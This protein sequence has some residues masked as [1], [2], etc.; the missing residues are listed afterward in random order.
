SPDRL[1]SIRSAFQPLREVLEMA[2]QPLLVVPPCLAVHARSR[3]L[4]EGEERRSQARDV[5]HVM[6]ERG[7]PHLLI[8]SCDLPYPLQR[9]RRVGP[10]RCPGR[11]LLARVS[12][13]PPPSLRCLRSRLPGVV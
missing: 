13:G 12:F 3:I 5:V 8:P 6:Q 9:T 7:E 10:A 11:V 2:L 4:L 1:R